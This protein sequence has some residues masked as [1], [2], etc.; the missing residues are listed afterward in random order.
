VFGDLSG[1]PREDLS[2]FRGFL[3]AC[4]A[5]NIDP[6]WQP[7]EWAPGAH[8]FMGGVVINER[9]ETGIRGL[10]ACGEA[11]AGIH[12]ANRVPGNALTETQVFGAIAGKY[13][14]KKALSVKST[15]LSPR[16]IHSI[17][18]RM[19]G[20]LKRGKGVDPLEVKEELTE[21]MSR[22]VGVLRDGDGLRRAHQVLDKIKKD[23]VGRLCLGGKRSCKRLAALLEVENLL[24]VGR[25]IALAAMERRETRGAQYREDY[26]ELDESWSKNIVLQLESGKTRVR[27]KPVVQSK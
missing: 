7:Y 14:A 25:L 26:P 2:K 12:G 19:E 13:A 5:E 22:Y 3:E 21:I 16:Q 1:V 18:D 27:M 11:A 8:H 20:I 15:S 23:K 6:T 4:A 10:Y 24:M 17:K 9:C